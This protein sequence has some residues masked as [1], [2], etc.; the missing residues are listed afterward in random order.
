MPT[1]N[2]KPQS[3]RESST[4]RKNPR[5][6][7]GSESYYHCSW[8]R[9]FALMD[10]RFVPLL[11][12]WGLRLTVN[13][14][15]FYAS[16]NRIA[17]HFGRDRTTVIS[18]L[19]ELV[20]LGWAEVI[21]KEPGKPVTYRFIEHEEWARNHPDCCVE[22]EIMPWEGEGDPLGARLHAISGGMTKFFPGQMDAL[23]KSGFEDDQIA[24][25]FRTFLDRNPQKGL[26]WKS[27]VYR[28][29]R[30]LLRLAKEL[31]A[32]NAENSRS[33]VSAGTDTYQSSRT[34]TPSR[35]EPTTTSRPQPTQVVEVSFKRALG[36]K[37]TIPPPA[38]QGRFESASHSLKASERGFPPSKPSP[39]ENALAA[40]RIR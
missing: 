5:L 20:H 16:V 14:E 13:T 7:A 12:S 39:T 33:K 11:Y 6:M 27:V 4:F 18:A 40:R 2:F 19:K 10:S 29:R 34:D 38:S 24:S 17:E 32:T 15:S 8:E 36:Q 9:H 26:E 35:V 1:E 37:A 25:E 23:R 3:E 30:H 28:F 21:H 22:K 31:H